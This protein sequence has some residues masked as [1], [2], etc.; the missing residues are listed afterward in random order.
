MVSP[1]FYEDQDLIQARNGEYFFVGTAPQRHAA[2]PAGLQ[3]THS[4]DLV[5]WS[6]PEVMVELGTPQAVC[7]RQDRQGL[8][9]LLIGGNL[10]MHLVSDD[11]EEWRESSRLSR[12]SWSPG[13]VISAAVTG[14]ALVAVVGGPNEMY[15]GGD[16]VEVFACRLGGGTTDLEKLE[17][18]PGVIGGMCDLAYDTHGDKVVATWQ[19]ASMR[20]NSVLPAGP[21]YTMSGQPAAWHN[22]KPEAGSTKVAGKP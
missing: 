6:T 11:F 2:L 16:I 19:T 12:I 8:Y 5:H 3:I 13:S 15:G 14:D 10:T 17:V 20:L 9:H 21:V 4:S 18:P 1:S 7:V 22:A